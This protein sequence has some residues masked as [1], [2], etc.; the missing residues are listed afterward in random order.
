MRGAFHK[1]SGLVPVDLPILSATWGPAT[2]AAEQTCLRHEM[3]C[4]S[5]TCVWQWRVCVCVCV[6]VCVFGIVDILP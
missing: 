4:P 2:R 3:A 6:C 1:S 5:P